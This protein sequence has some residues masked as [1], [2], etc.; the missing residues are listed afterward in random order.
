MADTSLA[1]KMAVGGSALASSVRV[2][3]A[4]ACASYPPTSTR[5]SLTGTPAAVMACR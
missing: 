1:A 5:S 4:D 2:H 3:S